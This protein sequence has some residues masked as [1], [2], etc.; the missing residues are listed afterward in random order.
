[1]PMALERTTTEA[2]LEGNPGSKV[3]FRKKLRIIAESRRVELAI[4]IIVLTYVPLI[5]MDVFLRA[6]MGKKGFVYVEREWN[7]FFFFVDN[8][9]LGLFLIEH[10]VKTY[11]YGPAVYFRDRF[12]I[13]DFCIC[14]VPFIIMWVQY[15]S[16]EPHPPFVEKV[17]CP[18]PI[19]PEMVEGTCVLDES[20]DV[21][22]SVAV[23]LGNIAGLLRL[24]RVFRLILVMNKLQKTREAASIMRKKAKY[25]RAG[26]PVEKVLDILQ[27]LKKT[28]DK[29]DDRD[30]INFIVDIIVNEQLYTVNMHGG[31]GSG[32]SAEMSAYLGKQGIQTQSKK[33]EARKEPKEGDK[34]AEGGVLVNGAHRNS[35]RR[36]SAVLTDEALLWVDR[37]MESDAVAGALRNFD[38]WDFNFFEFDA[39]TKG[40][41]L[42]PIVMHIVRRHALDEQLPI[43]TGNLI[44]YLTKLQAGYNAVPFHNYQHAADVCQGLNFFLLQEKV[45]RQISALDV[46]VMILSA[47]QHDFNHPGWNNAFL[48]ASRDE[49]AI[50][51][52]DAS[53]LES[54]HLAGSWRLMLTKGLDPYEGFSPEQYAEARTTSVSV[55]LGTDMKF[56]IDHLAKFKM[57]VGS[58]ALDLE[59]VDRKDLLLMLTMALH[60][61]DVS[62]PARPWNM[63]ME[64]SARVMEEFFR[65]GDREAELGLPVSAMMGRSNTNIAQ[66]QMGFMKVLILPFFEEWTSFLSDTIYKELVGNINISIK[67]WETQGEQVLGPR[68]A[69]IKNPPHKKKKA[70]ADAVAAAR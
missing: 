10:F 59:E 5:L 35:I 2:K 28:F 21:T 62:N 63:S 66:C 24:L 43:N 23:G 13:A 57:R 25:K 50:T 6:L 18:Y 70:S 22:G 46:Y 51:Y 11:A 45:A 32:I 37:L 19:T 48:V 38:N 42:V 30:N 68:L 65:Q 47:A 49:M 26:S 3:P 67:T 40:Q 14:L 34:E 69:M 4:M 17:S 54:F 8:I 15:G 33:P 16:E 53:V 27:K 29:P 39:L 7:I 64:W 31:E 1:M 58:G 12:N 9:F 55:I 52:N 36:G 56:H 41:S 44:R 60:A 61:A 20:E